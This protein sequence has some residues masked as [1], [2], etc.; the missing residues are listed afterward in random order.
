VRCGVRCCLTSGCSWQPRA[1]SSR[2]PWPAAAGS[3]AGPPSAAGRCYG[4]ARAAAAEPRSVRP[5]EEEER[6]P[7]EAVLFL[8]SRV[9]SRFPFTQSGFRLGLLHSSRSR[10]NGCGAARLLAWAF[11][12]PLS[13]SGL[14]VPSSGRVGHGPSARFFISRAGWGARYERTPSG[15]RHAM[16]S[17]PPY[18]GSGCCS[19]GPRRRL[20]NPSAAGRTVVRPERLASA[21]VHAAA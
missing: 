2:R 9:P 11:G 10:H 20:T 18:T 12:H 6:S 3:G 17:N 13:A 21:S 7:A 19:G 15:S 16:N 1:A 4:G 5:P 14:G 8:G